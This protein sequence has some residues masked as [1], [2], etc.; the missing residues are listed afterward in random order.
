MKY[1]KNDIRKYEEVFGT[2]YYNEK[3][4]IDKA[5]TIINWFVDEHPVISLLIFFAVLV[6]TGEPVGM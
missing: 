6:L 1:G 3:G 2:I 5:A 4:Q